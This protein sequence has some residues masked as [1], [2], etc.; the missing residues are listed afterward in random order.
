M[1]P[2]KSLI[3]MHSLSTNIMLTGNVILN[4]VS[5]GAIG[6]VSPV[7]SR[8]IVLTDLTVGAVPVIEV[9]SVLRKSITPPSLHVL[10]VWILHSISPPRFYSFGGLGTWR[11]TWSY[12]DANVCLYS[13]VVTLPYLQ[14]YGVGCP[15]TVRLAIAL[16]SNFH[17]PVQLMWFSCIH[18]NRDSY[19][20]NID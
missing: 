10:P 4:V 8:R 19:R 11:G 3:I 6:K 7:S 17:S 1:L 2:S 5:V 18:S 20:T 15:A 16:Y 9:K 14:S 12:A 13:H